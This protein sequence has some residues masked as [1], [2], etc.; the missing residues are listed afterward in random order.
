[1]AFRVETTQKAKRDLEAILD[2]L[3]AEEAG[4]T[5]LRWFRDLIQSVESLSQLPRRCTLAP[6]NSFF[7]FEVRQLLYGDRPYSYRIL[8][9]IKGDLVTV[10][11]I[12]RG[13]RKRLVG[14]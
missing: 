13:R 7:P 14:I 2:W 6:E 11:R 5:G 8:F 9:T 4:D 1:M 10:L 12:R 3:L